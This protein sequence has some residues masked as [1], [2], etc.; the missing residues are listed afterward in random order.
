MLEVACSK[1][2]SRCLESVWRHLSVPQRTLVAKELSTSER[3]KGDTYGHFLY[4]NFGLMTFVRQRQQ[5]LQAQGVQTKKQ[6]AL[7]QLLVD[8][9][10]FV[11]FFFFL[12]FFFS[13]DYIPYR[14][15][16]CNHHFIISSLF[17]LFIFVFS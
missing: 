9:G 1:Y 13:S 16:L 2:G 6:R 12:R 14:S 10:I 4:Y 5:W 15:G 8:K 7:K 3:I 17:I 11:T